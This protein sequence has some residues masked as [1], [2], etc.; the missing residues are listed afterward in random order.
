MIEQQTSSTKELSRSQKR[1][2]DDI[3][4]AALKIFDRDGFEAA[5][6]VDIAKEA[7]VAKGTLY[8]YFDTKAALLEGVIATAIM[9]TLQQIGDVAQNHDGTAKELLREQM[10]IA[11]TRM[12]SPEMSML[13][14]YMISGGRRH[15]RIAKFYYDN[16]IQ[17]GLEH[18]GQTLEFGVKTREFRAEA[19]KMDALV[20][21]GAPV[22]L[23]VWNILFQEMREIDPNKLTNELLDGVLNG[24]L[25]NNSDEQE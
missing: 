21:V 1:R 14:R 5:K 4:E 13:L 18:I 8:L 6:M 9:P 15:Q 12:A 20:L 16:V 19:S 2:R 11:A 24:I 3:V 23:A 17:K 7:D 10:R 22:Y 25:A